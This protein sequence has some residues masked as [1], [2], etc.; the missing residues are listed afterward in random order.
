MSVA[1]SR[2]NGNKSAVRTRV[3]H[4]FPDLNFADGTQFLGYTSLALA[5]IRA[6][7]PHQSRN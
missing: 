1:T 4:V 2:A 5:S 3:E 6:K 7:G